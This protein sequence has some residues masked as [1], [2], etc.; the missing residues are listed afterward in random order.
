MFLIRFIRTLLSLPF[1][2]GGQLTGIF[3]LPISIQLLRA[4]WWISADGQMGLKA[5]QAITKLREP[6]EAIGCAVAW[7]ETYPRVELAA[8]AGLLAAGA[9][10]ADI[11]RNMLVVSQQFPTDS[12]GLTELLEFTISKRFEPIGTAADC[13]RR[14]ENRSDL[15]PSVSGMIH[16]ELLWDAMLCGR[17][18]EARRRADY[19]LSVGDAPPAHVALSALARHHGNEIGA[20]RHIEQAKLPPAE[21]H[22]YLFLSACGIGDELEARAALQQLSDFNAS[23][24]E[25][26]THQVNAVRGRK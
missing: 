10:L 7:M 13:A 8:Y 23:L 21:L 22:Y 18:D 15:S 2:W 20:S 6:A 5:L 25:Y 1:L 9:G 12:L 17:L 24:A 3:Q 16:T 4:A 19:M 11:A 14:L 26:A